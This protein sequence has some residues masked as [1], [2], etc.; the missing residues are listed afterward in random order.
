MCAKLSVP[1]LGLCPS[2]R[3]CAG[4]G[5]METIAERTFSGNAMPLYFRSLSDNLSHPDCRGDSG[6]VGLDACRTGCG[7]QGD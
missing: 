5:T 4:Q 7:V 1:E 6:I 3:F 2:F